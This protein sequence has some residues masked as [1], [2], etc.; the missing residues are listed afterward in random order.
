MR[1]E[2]HSGGGSMMP[3][4]P[5]AS[6]S[7]TTSSS[8]CSTSHFSTTSCTWLEPR[9]LQ[10][11]DQKFAQECRARIAVQQADANLFGA[12]QGPRRE[13]RRVFELGDGGLHRLARLLAHVVLAVDDARYRHR[14]KA[15][16][17][18]DIRDRRRTLLAM[19]G[20]PIAAGSNAFSG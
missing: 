19:F 7:R 10:A 6:N 2:S 15:R 18:G 16:I 17:G 11:A 14:R 12:G 20:F 9:L 13:I 3:S 4:T 8:C 1:F 5:V